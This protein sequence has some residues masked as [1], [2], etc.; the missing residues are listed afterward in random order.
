[1]P[2]FCTALLEDGQRCVCRALPGKKFCFGHSPDTSNFH[3][4]C[5]YFSQKGQPC[6]GVPLRGHDHCF[7]HS[8]RNRRAQHS[9]LPLQ[10]R[11]RRDK[12]RLKWLVS[13]PLPQP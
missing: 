1:M 10:P 9:P 12:E 3:S 11:T 4:Q 13:T 6:R 5:Q 7:A 2:R 8:P